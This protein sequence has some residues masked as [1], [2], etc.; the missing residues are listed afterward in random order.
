MQ[1]GTT[2]FS[3]TNEWLARTL[4]LDG[5]LRRVAE[6]ELG[7]G[8]EL[9]GFQTWRSFPSLTREEVTAFRR[10]VDEL[11]LEPAALGA[12]AD[13]LRRPGRPMTA[14]DAVEFLRPQIAVARALGFPLVRLHA[15]IPLEALETLAPIAETAGITLATELQGGQTPD[16]H[17]AAGLVELRERLETPAIALALDFSVAMTAVPAPFVE[18]VHAAGLAPEDL[19]ALV[20][21]WASGATL[22]E[23]FGALAAID[24]PPQALL[25]A[26]SGFVRFGR[27]EPDAWAPLVPAIAY[28]HAK[29]WLPAEDGGDPTVR[30]AELLEVLERGGFEGVVATEWGGNAWLD[31]DNTDAFSV[32]SRHS[33]FCRAQISEPA[34]EVPARP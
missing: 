15:G 16:S 2:A 5:L 32:V 21:L 19:A 6:H 11:G 7:P 30:T 10:T 1:L 13:L 8:L 24:A 18:A 17:V 29:F 28:A 26:Q 20:G 14:A 4:A 9:I 31:A 23:L 34:L 25:E 3:F 12:Y 33:A 22:P 27:Q